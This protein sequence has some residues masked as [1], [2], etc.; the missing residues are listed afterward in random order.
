MKEVF[1][2][3]AYGS[4]G[5][6]DHYCVVL[7]L[8]SLWSRL[9][10]WDFPPVHIRSSGI[11]NTNTIKPTRVR[12]GDF[13]NAWS[14]SLSF[15]S[16]W[17]HWKKSTLLLSAMR[18]LVKHFKKFQPAQAFLL[19]LEGLLWITYLQHSLGRW[20]PSMLP[21][22]FGW[23]LGEGLAWPWEPDDSHVPCLCVS[24]AE[25]AESHS[26]ANVNDPVPL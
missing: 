1:H 19:P 14:I 7:L 24:Y 15:D 2:T 6:E 17:F 21:W 3:I 20:C 25:T 23:E 10:Q 9:L 11:W 18:K 13:V 8:L 16:H 4:Y 22:D 5:D 12:S 26:Y